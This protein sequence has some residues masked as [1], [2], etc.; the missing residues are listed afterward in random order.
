M[1]L[2][3]LV[4]R[5]FNHVH[6]LAHGSRQPVQA[7]ISDMNIPIIIVMFKYLYSNDKLELES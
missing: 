7:T 6:A 5:N 1:S 3:S 4:A 2:S